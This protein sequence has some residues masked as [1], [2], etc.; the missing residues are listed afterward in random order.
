MINDINK[1]WIRSSFKIVEFK[2]IRNLGGSIPGGERLYLNIFS[3]NDRQNM[4]M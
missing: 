4:R 1:D 2:I 3:W